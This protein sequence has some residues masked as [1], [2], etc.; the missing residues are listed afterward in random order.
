MARIDLRKLNC[1]VMRISNTT[2]NL[3]I[4]MQYIMEKNRLQSRHCFLTC[5]HFQFAARVRH[6][7]LGASKFRNRSSWNSKEDLLQGVNQ[8]KPTQSLACSAAWLV[9]LLK[10]AD[11]ECLRS[12]VRAL[13]GACLRVGTT[14]SGIDVCSNI[15]QH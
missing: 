11:V 7:W 12:R 3:Q 13:D 14:C 10:L 5:P 2:P 15:L 1:P 8:S 6:S 4:Q 9:G